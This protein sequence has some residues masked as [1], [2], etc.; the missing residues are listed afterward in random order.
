MFNMF[1]SFFKWN[2]MKMLKIAYR[3]KGYNKFE[4]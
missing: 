1:Q 4:L 3:I 2:F